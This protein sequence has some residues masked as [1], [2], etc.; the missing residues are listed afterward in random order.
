MIV[1]EIVDSHKHPETC[2]GPIFVKKME[3]IFFNQ[4]RKKNNYP[5]LKS[6]MKECKS[7]ISSWKFSSISV[8]LSEDNKH[9]C[10]MEVFLHY[11]TSSGTTQAI[12]QINVLYMM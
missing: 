4:Q 7:R 11:R 5:A 9:K 6:R 10:F 12:I 2:I 8:C 3:T 1:M